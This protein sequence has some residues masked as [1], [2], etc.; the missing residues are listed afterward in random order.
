MAIIVILTLLAGVIGRAYLIY[1]AILGTLMVGYPPL[2]P[3]AKANR[4]RLMVVI[5][6]F[7]LIFHGRGNKMQACQDGIIEELTKIRQNM[8]V[9]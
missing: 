8:E 3:I 6:V 9:R 1:L 2:V 7:S 4:G 5:I